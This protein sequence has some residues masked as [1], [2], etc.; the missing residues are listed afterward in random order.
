MQGRGGGVGGAPLLVEGSIALLA[1]SQ[2]KILMEKH[3]VQYPDNFKYL[4]FFF[5][6]FFLYRENRGKF[7][8]SH[9]GRCC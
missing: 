3:L 7:D 8:F 9:W 6:F 2:S 4:N 5:L 1:L